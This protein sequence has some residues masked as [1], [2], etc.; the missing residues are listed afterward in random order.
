MHRHWRSSQNPPTPHP[1]NKELGQGRFRS[2]DGGSG[3]PEQNGTNGH[4][5]GMSTDPAHVLR[6]HIIVLS[7]NSQKGLQA[8]SNL[9]RDYVRERSETG[10]VQFLDDL[11]H[12]LCTRRT[13]LDLPTAQSV[14]SLAE[15]LVW[16]ER[17]GEG[18]VKPGKRLDCPKLCFAFTGQG[19]QWHAMGR[20]LR[21]VY[22]A[23]S[24]SISAAGAHFTQ[25][26]AEWE[27]K[28]ELSKSKKES[29]VNNATLSQ[30]L[31][32]A[33]QI[34][35]VDL[36][37]TWN[38]QPSVVVGHSSGEI[39]A[40]YAAG[41]LSFTDA[42][43]VAYHR[44]RLV[45]TIHKRMPERQ[46]AMMAAGLSAEQAS[47][48]IASLPLS[49]GTICVACINGPSSVTVSGDKAMVLRLQD[50]LEAERIFNRLLTVDTAYHSHHMDI[51]H[52]EYI[53]AL[54]GLHPRSFANSVRMVSSVSGKEIRG[55]DLNP[56]YWGQ[57]LV[58]M[59]R[60][61][62]ALEKTCLLPSPSDI[63][64]IIEIGPHAALA[65]PIKQTLKGITSGAISV[66][67]YSALVRNVDA[68]KT[69]HEMVCELFIKGVD[70]DLRAVNSPKSSTPPIV[71]TDLPPHAWDHS[72]HW[73]ESR[74]SA[75]YRLRERPRHDVLG[76]PSLDNNP[77]EPR[78]RK[79]LSVAETPW[80]RGHAVQGQM[81]Y[82]ASG[83]ICMA[84]EAVRQ[85]ISKRDQSWEN[86]I[87][88]F[89]DFCIGRALLV[90]DDAE[91]IETIFSLRPS[92]CTARESSST[93]DE[94][95]VFSVSSNGI[96]TEHCRG[97]VSVQL[98]VK[99]GGVEGNRENEALENIA[100]ERLSAGQSS[101]NTIIEPRKL[102]EALT[103]LGLE[104]T[105][106]FRGLTSVRTEP[107]ASICTFQIPET[108]YTMPG[109]FEQPNVVHPTTL[110]LCFQ[111][112]MPALMTAGSLNAPVVINFI[113]EL[114]I[115]SDV[116]STSGTELLAHLMAAA[117]G[118]SKH[119][120]NITVSNTSKQVPSWV[121]NA[122]GLVYTSLGS[123]SRQ[124]EEISGSNLRLCHR[125][126]WS[127]DITLV[128]PQDVRNL[129]AVGLSDDS[130]LDHL[131]AISAFGY[132]IIRETLPLIHPEDEVLMSFHHKKLFD[133][134]RNSVT[135]DHGQPPHERNVASLGVDGEL[136][137]RIGS[138]LVDILKGTV[139]P[140]TLLMK[141]DLLYQ[142]YA[143]MSHRC[144]T[145]LAEYVRLLSFKKP[146]M[147]VLEIGAGTGSATV[148]LLEAFTKNSEHSG[149]PLLNQYV[150]TDVS[151][152]FFEKARALLSAW[153]DVVEFRKLDIETSVSEQGF[154]EGIYDLVVA[155]NVLHATRIM[156]NTVKNVRKLLKPGGKL[157]LIELTEPSV[158]TSLVFGTL[159][160]WWSGV[161]DGRI[162]SPLLSVEKWKS[163]LGT[164]GFSGIDAWFPDYPAGQGQ[165][166]STIISS[167]VEDNSLL[168][169]FPVHIIH[170]ETDVRFASETAE[171]FKAIGGFGNVHQSTL[172]EVRPTGTICVVMLE[173]DRPLLS[174]C[175]EAEF[176]SIRRMLSCAKGVLWLTKG[177]AVECSDPLSGLI[178]GLA[179]S[180]RSEQQNA[181]KLITLDL[182]MFQSSAKSIA[183]ISSKLLETSFNAATNATDIDFEY[184]ERNGKILIPRLVPDARV[185]EYIDSRVA[186]QAPQ[187]EHFFQPGRPLSLEVGTA[188]LLE[189][190]HWADSVRNSRQ[191]ASDELRIE[192]RLEAIN[193]RDIMI[194]MGQLEGYFMVGECSGI[195]MEVGS[196]AKDRF[197]VGDRVCAVG[198]GSYANS[199]IIKMQQAH[200][201]PDNMSLEVAASIPVSYTTA[202]Y[203]LKSLANLRKDETL[204][205][206]SAAG[207]LGQA[208]IMIA[209][210][211]GAR[212]FATVGSVEKK[213]FIM[214]NFGIPQEHIFSSR[215]TTFSRGIRRL[216][217]GKGVDVVLNSLAGE[218]LRET[219]KCVA[220]FGRFIEVGKRDAL[221][222]ARMD[223]DIFDRHV[224]YASVDLGMVF[225]EKPTLFQ[226]L[227]QDVV[228]LVSTGVVGMIRPIEVMPLS[229]IEGAFRHIRTG[230]HMGKVVLKADIDTRVKVRIQ[231][232]ITIFSTHRV[233]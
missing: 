183:E 222:N 202:Y 161:S 152:G 99:S 227:L 90:P 102:Y 190:L 63:S 110:D 84:V 81:I 29:R 97:L 88:R 6:R 20:E 185:N 43:S 204:L 95:R 98:H 105:G 53:E 123:E 79:Y 177:G 33:I 203:S 120:A 167:A 5:V 26:G 25:L 172:A 13:L 171:Q 228:E 49:E 133:W 135:N 131:N 27:L 182:D 218:A 73:H 71:L 164:T 195:V 40:A 37:N 163:L 87:Y 86:Q 122:T 116:C 55:E 65:G 142:Y 155:S 28:T 212:I 19:A 199:A 41:A 197:Q 213:S 130:A 59:V 15:L 156:K 96:W 108:K 211:L 9:L 179:R 35:L 32:T 50:K 191:L 77:L 103:A 38:I 11:A 196:D 10:Q 62:A 45:E 21:E 181:M 147:K 94:F 106:A 2:Q 113:E 165:Q 101:Y 60:F 143:N 200:P 66:N 39:A 47:S 42:L 127:P 193:F 109:A 153:D 69:T 64:A 1:T 188:G 67:Y 144:Y 194:A 68:T 141:D 173:L 91:G 220:K 174:L 198:T 24:K 139:D 23:F 114:S 12:T 233:L 223:M 74:L 225:M 157:C 146:A 36:L 8:T 229:D 61:S 16:L 151:T 176:D 154:E 209:Q 48:F 18:S 148:P 138:H 134:M 58:S 175:T 192:T 189:T 124:S 70:V 132:R 160:G 112:M 121:M 52:D 115:S 75:Q 186:K 7:G 169:E 207:A 128:E 46:G 4:E 216:T 125:I 205:I 3:S 89:R 184:A 149:R 226:E 129:C 180:T 166:L 210:H 214:D 224:M 76:V 104:Y 117:C 72:A 80:L 168:R 221:M 231:F 232:S 187:L 162:D 215:L 208:A 217:G 44:G 54:D 31:C 170:T 92:P 82:P 34:A 100:R 83:Y 126:T 206:H 140:L 111:A 118:Q 85:Q 51:I 230:K 17:V 150:F 137:G 158:M 136:L 107:L 22:P 93:W 14:D 201:I 145:Q 56:A 119:K 78:W 30:P 178:T 159:E 57:N 219:C